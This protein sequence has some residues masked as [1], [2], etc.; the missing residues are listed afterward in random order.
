MYNVG[1]CGCNRDGSALCNSIGQC[2][3]KENVAGEQCDACKPG[4]FGFPECLK[5]ILDLLI[6]PR[7][8]DI[9][10]IFNLYQFIAI[11]CYVFL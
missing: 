1:D 8:C 10:S 4:L 9:V 11:H 2:E 5:G 7:Y 6:E 3:C